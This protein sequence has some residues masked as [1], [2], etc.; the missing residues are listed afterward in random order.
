MTLDLRF[1]VAGFPAG[2]QTDWRMC[3][4]KNVIS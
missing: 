2:M 1:D 4:K 3:K